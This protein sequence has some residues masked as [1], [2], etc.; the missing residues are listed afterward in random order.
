MIDRI[1]RYLLLA[2]SVLGITFSAVGLVVKVGSFVTMAFADQPEMVTICHATSS[3]EHPWEEITAAY[4]AVYG[5]AGH[6]SEPGSPNAG[7]EQDYEGPC[8][9]V[10]P[11]AEPTQEPTQ[12]PTAEPTTEPTEEPTQE[13]TAE[14]TDIPDCE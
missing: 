12:E 9:T 10:E 11:T 4:P 13:P 8:V 5:P 3:Q 14:P 1:T 6:F 7:H 2:A